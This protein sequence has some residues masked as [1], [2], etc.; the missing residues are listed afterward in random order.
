MAEF[1]PRPPPTVLER[2]WTIL[3]YS[4]REILNASKLANSLGASLQTVKRYIDVLAGLLL[5]RRLPPL[6]ANV[7]KRLVRSQRGIGD[8]LWA[9]AGT[10]S[11]LSSLSDGSGALLGGDGSILLDLLAVKRAL[12]RRPLCQ[13][14][15][16]DPMKS[17]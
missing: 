14:A 6:R 1:G 12:R 8:Q 15:F 17:R 5:V 10:G 16:G 2:L 9:P 4:Q 7:R 3:A 11:R 13:R